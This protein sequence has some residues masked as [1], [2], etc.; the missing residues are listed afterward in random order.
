MTKSLKYGATMYMPALRTDLAEAGNGEK[1]PGLR[2]VVF[3]TE[4]SVREEDLPLALENLRS[5]LSR[6]RDGGIFRFVRPRDPAV[7][8]AVLSM[9]GIGRITGFV[10]PKADRGTLPAYFAL[11]ERREAF[12]IMP[13]LETPAVFDPWELARLRDYLVG[14]PVRDRITALR[15]G[16]LDLFSILR[17]RRD[18]DRSIYESPVG[19]AIDGLITCFKPAGLEL[20]APGFEGLESPGVL[21]G[22][23]ELDIGR[24]L[25][26]KTA[27]HP[28]QVETINSSYRART[29]ELEAA[30]AI[31]DPARPAVFRLNGRMCEK[32]VHTAW[33]RETVERARIF[34]TADVSAPMGMLSYQPPSVSDN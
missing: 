14:S 32:A 6:L 2:S 21:A 19:H 25:Y 28:C 17:L 13:I 18:I 22:E 10:L 12:E 33:A 8:E 7:L 4:D 9:R 29:D 3:C 5:A 30:G 16:G 15:I 1:F 34:G 11:L 31:L 27:V 26:S 23:L 20:T 24:G